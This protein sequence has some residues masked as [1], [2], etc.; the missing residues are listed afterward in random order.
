M[1]KY[2][3]VYIL[4][5]NIEENEEELRYSVR[6]V[7]KNFP[8][9]RVCFY[10][11]TPK[12]IIP[13][14]MV[15]HI[16]NHPSKITRALQ[17][18]RVAFEDEQLTE[19]IWLFNDDFF[20]MQPFTDFSPIYNGNLLDYANKISKRRGAKTKYVFRLEKSDLYL[21]TNG[22]TTLNYETHTPFLFNRKKGIFIFD[23]FFQD[24]C[25]FRCVYGNIYK[26]GGRD[27]NDPKIITIKSQPNGA[28]PLL[29]TNDRS[30]KNG[31]VGKFI[32]EQFPEPSKFEI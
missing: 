17:T 11:G 19:N 12:T 7:E 32:R 25:L 15:P 9:N 24:N 22:F 23:N 21:K 29:S 5:N 10:G 13:D 18:L 16:Q 3:V 6:S 2:D 27:M 20:I 28:A 30:F 26:I 4:K 1:E 14:L 31:L 8:Y